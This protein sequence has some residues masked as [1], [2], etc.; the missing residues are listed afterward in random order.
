MQEMART[1]QKLAAF[2]QTVVESLRTGVDDDT[3]LN[4]KQKFKD[5]LPYS[6]FKTQNGDSRNN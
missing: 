4:E 2:K 3:N 1:I 5:D 6:N